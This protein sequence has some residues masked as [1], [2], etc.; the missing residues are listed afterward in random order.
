MVRVSCN[1]RSNV[2]S[3]ALMCVN[4]TVN[5]ESTILHKGEIPFVG[6]ARIQHTEPPK[7]NLSLDYP[8][9]CLEKMKAAFQ[10]QQ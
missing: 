2:H 9:S 7:F 10:C 6:L 8:K 5:F 4:N 1:V 3:V